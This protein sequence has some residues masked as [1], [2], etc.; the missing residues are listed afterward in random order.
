[1]KKLIFTC[2]I[3]FTSAVAFSQ[4]RSSAQLSEPEIVYEGP[5]KIILED[6]SVKEG[7]VRHSRITQRRATVTDSNGESETFKTKDMKEFYINNLHFVKVE[8]AGVGLKDPDFAIELSDEGAAIKVYEVCHQE[9]ITTDTGG[10]VTNWP[11]SREY[12]VQMPGE[13]KIKGVGDIAYMPS[14]KIAKVDA[15]KACPELEKKISSK[16]NGYSYGMISNEQMK[17]DVFLEISRAY[18]QCQDSK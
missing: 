12:F 5:G 15:I 16:A 6:G 13:D 4:L 11:T 2:L 7:T 1:M 8:T 9:N 10:E 18:E 3:L 14:K 17:R